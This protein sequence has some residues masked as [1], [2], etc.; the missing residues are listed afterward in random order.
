MKLVFACPYNLL[1]WAMALG[2]RSRRTLEVGFS[3]HG[4]VL[5][6]L[7]VYYCYITWTP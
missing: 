6:E 4:L 7:L 1:F 3:V 2:M 5:P